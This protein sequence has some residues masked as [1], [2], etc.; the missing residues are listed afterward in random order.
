MS[1]NQFKQALQPYQNT[2]PAIGWF[3]SYTPEEI[4]HAAGFHTYGIK[5]SS[6]CEDDDVYLGRSLCSYVHS[7][8]GGA[9]EGRYA[10]LDGVILPHC[11]ECMRRL[12]DGWVEWNANV[13]PRFAYQFSVPTVY[14]DLSVEYFSRTLRKFREDLERQFGHK[15]PD[16]ALVHSIHVYNK[17]RSLLNRLYELRKREKPPVSGTQVLDILDLCLS[18][19]KERFNEHFEPFLE[20]LEATDKGVFDDFRYRILLYGGIYNPA[21]VRYIEGDGVGGIVTCEDACLG[22]RYLDSTV[23]L[24][25]DPDPFTALSRR[26]LGKMPCARMAGDRE[27][28][29][30]PADLVRLV[31]EF[32]A[33]GVIYFATKRCDNLFWEYQ[34]VKD[35]LE[36]EKIPLKKIE[37][38]IAGDIPQREIRSFIELLDY[39]EA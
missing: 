39:I 15:I 31:R 34:F 24:E 6:G 19:P 33:D 14:T 10:Y 36:A 5:K 4:L 13:K 32:R 3:C 37:G 25:A 18:T 26:Y 17:T 2:G 28:E 23:D 16:E 8:F 9:L 11:C 38:D 1:Y 35:A 29:R 12:Y 21:I 22:Y 27:G 7:I 20:E 30:M